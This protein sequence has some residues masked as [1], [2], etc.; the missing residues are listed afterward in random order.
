M[1]LMTLMLTMEPSHSGAT[2]DCVDNEGDTALHEAARENPEV[3]NL[4]LKVD[5]DAL[6]LASFY[7]AVEV[8]KTLLA[9]G[10]KSDMVDVWGDSPLH[11]AAG[12]NH[13]TV[14]EM[15][16]NSQGSVTSWECY[17]QE[18]PRYC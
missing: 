15:I 7:G 3:V 14:V 6:H 8:V 18:S 4:L 12:R 13:H 5:K 10:A 17:D 9:A 2:M 11:D 16:L 1:N